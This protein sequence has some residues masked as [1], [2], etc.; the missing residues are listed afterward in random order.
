[1]VASIHSYGSLSRSTLRSRC[2]A[3]GD[4]RSDGYRARQPGEREHRGAHDRWERD[5]GE[6]GA[7]R[8]DQRCAEGRRLGDADRARRR[9]GVGDLRQLGRDDEEQRKNFN[10]PGVWR[11]CARQCRARL[12]DSVVGEAFLQRFEEFDSHTVDLSEQRNNV[13]SQLVIICSLP[14]YLTQNEK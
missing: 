5:D 11:G 7:A 12:A 6:T 1:M 2:Q 8:Q 4:A 14:Q 10:E 3:D 9:T 13:I